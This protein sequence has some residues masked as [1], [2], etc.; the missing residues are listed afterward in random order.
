[1]KLTLYEYKC[2]ACETPVWV[3][4]DADRQSRYPNCVEAD[5]CSNKNM[6]K[7]GRVIEAEVSDR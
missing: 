2:A 7:T 6:V 3:H 4:W 5:D 1:M